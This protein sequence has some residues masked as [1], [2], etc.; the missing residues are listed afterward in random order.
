M[1]PLAVAYSLISP[2]LVLLRRTVL[3]LRKSGKKSFLFVSY[4]IVCNIPLLRIISRF[5]SFEESR[6]LKFN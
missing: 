4:N 1:F 3:N 6:Y 2:A 5:N